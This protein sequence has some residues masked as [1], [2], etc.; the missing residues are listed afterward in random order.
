MKKFFPALNK[1][2][3]LIFCENAGGSQIPEQVLNSVSNF[4]E[5]YYVQPGANNYLSK[6]HSKNLNEINNI[7]NT[8]LNNVN[9]NIIYGNSCSQLMYNLSHSLE[10]YLKVKN[11]NIVLTNFNHE[12]CITPFERIANKNNLIIKWWSLD[13]C[14]ENKYTINYDTLFES[15]DQNTSLVVL[16]HVSNILGN[17]IDIK[18]LTREIKKINS[19][20]KVLVDGVAYM[21][22][23]LIDVNSYN[24][25]YYVVSFYKFCG[26][27]ISALYVN[28]DSINNSINQ[29]HYFFDNLDNNHSKKLE[30]G[31]INYECAH[32][33]LGLKNYLIDFARFFNYNESKNSNKEIIF[34]RKLIEFVYEKIYY[35][36]K[37]MC[38][39][40]NKFIENNNNIEVLQCNKTQ[41]IPIYSL[42]FKDYN[43]NNI[44]L[45]LNELGVI[46]K[47]GSFYCD[48]L[49]ENLALDNN[50]LRFSLMHYN[51]FDE[52]NKIIEY[53]KEFKKLNINYNFTFNGKYKNFVTEELKKS[54]SNL[55]VD[56][57]YNNKRYRAYSLL[58]IED[59]NNISIM[60]DLNFYQS[61]DYNSYNGNYLREYCNIE[62]KI[63]NDECFKFFVKTFV[64]TI[65]NELQ[66]NSIVENIKY[67][68]VHQIRVYTE[69]NNEINLV[70][71]GIHQ[72]GYNFIAMCCVSRKNISGA[73]SNIYDE[74][75]NIVH[76]VQLQEGEMLILN[77]NKM[78][79][80]VTP[81][82]LMNNNK[83]IK[84]GYRD[85]FVFT[86][87]S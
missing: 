49:F 47:T 87:I 60:G 40:F 19:N 28:N 62:T 61:Q 56:K 83:E 72:D 45:I 65:K 50:V 21:P 31:G 57:Y 81:I 30:I 33:L 32:S 8:I 69:K 37:I 55:Q 26:L 36:E 24:V 22:H 17:I 7:T 25:D 66:K 77:D 74:S 1:Y 86:T 18:Y 84:E 71:E 48:R 51:T 78:Y 34:D 4:I 44:N 29:N 59:L 85:V 10:E 42:L 20:T 75:K 35:Y 79:H 73:I 12:A 54:F 63:L 27:R 52:I 41:K 14:N 70:P 15:I 2:K 3:N 23:G 16:P 5:N 53:L 76:S 82:T 67:I 46:T 13:S 11:G 58:N 68:Q 9:G 39:M 80:D 64:D 38:N 6:K 43:I